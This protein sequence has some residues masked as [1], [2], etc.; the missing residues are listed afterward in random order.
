M[1]ARLLLMPCLLILANAAEVATVQPVCPVFVGQEINPVLGFK[2]TLDQP[3]KL[4]G[5][6]LSLAGTSRMQDV[7]QVKIFRGKETPASAGGVAVADLMP[8]TGT[9]NRSCDLA[10]EAGEHWFWVSV[11]L[12]PSA[13]IDGKVDV[14]LNRLKI[15]GAVV[16]PAVQSPEVSQRIGVVVR[17]PGDDKSK[18][19][20]I[21]GLVRTK[22]GVLIA[23]YDIRYRNA[24]DLPADI[25]VGVSRST[26]GGKTW[27]ANWIA[28]FRKRG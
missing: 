1:K 28:D 13:D 17:K 19:Y 23:A 21:P 18:A 27:E 5:I 25:D 20:R 12:K 24:G 3:A 10:L 26:D 14:A 16:Q 2:M 22:K 11:S 7:E 6:E 15:G 4:E 8:K 9:M